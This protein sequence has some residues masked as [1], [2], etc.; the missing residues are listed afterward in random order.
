MSS[1]NL[2]PTAVDGSRLMVWERRTQWW[3]TGFA[4]AFLVGYAWLVLETSLS[5]RG[6]MTID[7]LLNVT[8]V[9]F[10]LDYLVRQC[11]AERKWRFFRQN[12]L[13]LST[14]LLSMFRQL[15]ALRLLTMIEVL[16]GGCTTRCAA[17]WGCT[18]PQVALVGVVASLA[19]LD[20]ER[21]APDAIT[22]FGDAVWWTVATMSTVSSGDRYPVTAEGRT[23]GATLMVAGIA[24]LG[25]VTASIASVFLENLRTDEEVETM[26]GAI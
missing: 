4:V 18:C 26:V 10:G 23:V 9:M 11:F 24:S 3:L 1:G 13:D 15:R 7:V 17:G 12:L 19:V 5:P 2:T 8:W 25:V 21:N 14:L 6:R 16:H 22:S 20:A